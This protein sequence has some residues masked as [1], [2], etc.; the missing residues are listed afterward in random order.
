[1]KTSK[2]PKL[3]RERRDQPTIAPAPSANGISITAIG[4]R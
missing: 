1:M 4:V 2:R 3:L